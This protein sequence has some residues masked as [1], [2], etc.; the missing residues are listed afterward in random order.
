MKLFKLLLTF[1][2]T[3]LIFS[4]CSKD[5]P[6]YILP[7]VDIPN[8]VL[9]IVPVNATINKG[10]TLQYKAILVS[11]GGTQTDV[12][13][14]N[15]TWSVDDNTTAT[16][17]MN[18]VVTGINGGTTNVTASYGGFSA[19]TTLT[20]TD[21]N[22]VSLSVTP[23]QTLSIVGLTTQFHAEAIY[24]DSTTQD[25]TNDATWSSLK[26]A[27]ATVDETGLATSLQDGNVTIK[28][29]FDGVDSNG[30][31]VIL[32]ASVHS[33][34]V[35]PSSVSLPINAT[36]LYS[37]TLILDDNNTID[38]SHDVDWAST[39]GDISSISEEGVLTAYKEGHNEIYALLSY[40]GKYIYANA[41]VTVLP[42]SLESIDVT[43]K[44][45]NVP[46]G[47][48]GNYFAVGTYS[49]G[50]T[51][52]ITNQVAWSSA[53]TAVGT[54][55]S[56]GLATALSVGTTEAKATLERISG[57]TTATVNPAT[58]EK[59]SVVPAYEEMPTHVKVQY[60]VYG[61]Y[62]DKSIVSLTDKAS[63]SIPGG[64]EK[65]SFDAT[66]K[67]LLT[68]LE[69]GNVK[70][71]ASFGGKSA[72]AILDIE[73]PYQLK[74]VKITPFQSTVPVGTFGNFTMIATYDIGSG[75]T[76]DVD[77]TRQC[78][79]SS[80][81]PDNVTIDVYGLSEAI[82]VTQYDDAIIIA[83][84]EGSSYSATV[85]VSSATL[86]SI[87]VTPAYAVLAV[88]SR[89]YYTAEGIYSDHSVHN[90][91]NSVHW[92][93]E[94]S[95]GIGYFDPTKFGVFVATTAGSD[96]VV[97]TLGSDSS[98]V[99][100]TVKDKI[101]EH[102]GV[103]P[104][105]ELL[106]VGVPKQFVAI[107]YFTDGSED[108]ITAIAAWSSTDS[109]S[110]SVEPTTGLVDPL[111]VQSTAFEIRA[112]YKGEAGTSDVK[113]HGPPSI[114]HLEVSP[115]DITLK[116]GELQQYKATLFLDAN[117]TKLDVTDVVYWS[118][119][120]DE[121]A[122][123]SNDSG[124]KGVLNAIAAGV[125]DVNASLG[126][127]ISSGTTLT[128]ETVSTLQSIKITPI[129][130]TRHIDDNGRFKAE[131][132]YTDSGST[133]FIIRDISD[134]VTWRSS[135]P[136]IASIVP[137]GTEGGSTVGLSD[138][139][140]II[141]AD[142]DDKSDDT[143]LT[144]ESTLDFFSCAITPLNTTILEG[145]T[146]QLKLTSTYYDSVSGDYSEVDDTLNTTWT[147]R[148]PSLVSFDPLVKG[149][150]HADA[151]TTGIGAKIEATCNGGAAGTEAHVIVKPA[152][153]TLTGIEIRPDNVNAPLKATFPYY[154][155]ATFSDGNESDITK[156]VVW[157]SSDEVVATISNA[158]GSEGVVNTLSNS[159]TVIKAIYELD[160]TSE[161]DT[162]DLNVSA[163]YVT[164]IDGSCAPASIAV[165]EKAQCNCN[166]HYS[167]SSQGSC[168]PMA[169][170]KA[171]PT[172]SVSFST[173]VQGETTG[174]D[175]GTTNI[176]IEFDGKTTNRTI[177]IVP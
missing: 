103:Y 63:W 62:S 66:K 4:A 171:T 148:S 145:E 3:L 116:E 46:V 96:K 36:Q 128:I 138:G 14:T 173:T 83:R 5:D 15:T 133:G 151:V 102:I 42:A 108:D 91:T 149:L 30:T 22:V 150:V 100:V 27:K 20:V 8:S 68:T 80:S 119:T 92:S 175:V 65:A 90:I 144:I 40:E 153:P 172:G 39:S 168:T 146:Q 74:Y 77:V 174:L 88:D 38:V 169:T 176:Q 33:L 19:E 154:A 10:T 159:T 163:A 26:P 162:T 147:S 17:D 85:E 78:T 122:S 7:S 11:P 24:D 76:L 23:A 112:D 105:S 32:S 12:T 161:S 6:R 111:A 137:T 61:H 35:K 58:L 143:V 93:L 13:D 129:D 55:D 79:W 2:T 126:S 56:H 1:M 18:A 130:P 124:N 127:L 101:I 140:T 156:D 60:S 114:D 82:A 97:A 43:P 106:Y 170:F 69:R 113:V 165:G 64:T 21:K 104:I 141:T 73:E 117:K 51:R 52:D 132:N 158:E 125:L 54:I 160:S 139:T 134:I 123:I 71:T 152:A 89:Q 25:V 115:Q 49:D 70:P 75:K 16:I 136:V 166:A 167:D 48:Y 50:S 29:T 41:K 121:F 53:D 84:F 135:D 9:T 59:L 98:S 87:V 157:S 31:L 95:S 120:E 86:E 67:G 131:G 57:A 142:L 177:T 28:A 99:S 37:A 164:F 72:S 81:L 118:L 47:A 34:E 110:A 94:S 44:N 155:Y 45:L 109:E 107:A